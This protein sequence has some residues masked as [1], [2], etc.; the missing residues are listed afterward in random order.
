MSLTTPVKYINVF[1]KWA[2]ATQR[3]VQVVATLMSSHRSD[4]DSDM[5]ISE[6]SRIFP[7]LDRLKYILNKTLKIFILIHNSLLSPFKS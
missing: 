1:A 5:Q 2:T 4:S 3:H 7:V 6:V